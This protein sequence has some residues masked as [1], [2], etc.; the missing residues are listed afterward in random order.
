MG[1]FFDKPDL[2]KSK[3]LVRQTR[4]ALSRAV[5]H[6]TGHSFLRKHNRL[7]GETEHEECRLCLE[8]EESSWHILAECPA[9]TRQ[10][11]RHLKLDTLAA[12]TKWN[13][14]QM[15]A[16]LKIQEVIDLEQIGEDIE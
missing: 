11:I 2:I 10:R 9:L 8:D 4:E 7:I 13:A 12:V 5:R 3:I 15:I 6:L 1:W 14:R 16:M